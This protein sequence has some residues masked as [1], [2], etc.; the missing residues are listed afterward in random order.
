VRACVRACERAS[1]AVAVGVDDALDYLRAKDDGDV[2]FSGTLVSLDGGLVGWISFPL[3]HFGL[4][5]VPGAAAGRLRRHRRR[6]HA[7]NQLEPT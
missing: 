5:L 6:M 7:H 1:V 3:S 4:Y 2:I